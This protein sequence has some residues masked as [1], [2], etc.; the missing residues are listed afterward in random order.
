MNGFSFFSLVLISD[1]GLSTLFTYARVKS[2]CHARVIRDA[3]RGDESDSV[4]IRVVSHER[5]VSIVITAVLA[6][7]LHADNIKLEFAE[8]VSEGDN[9]IA[10]SAW[11]FTALPTGCQSIISAWSTRSARRLWSKRPAKVDNAR[12]LLNDN[13]RK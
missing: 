7:A 9:P 2:I 12:F 10:S 6:H 11:H 5:C 8:S 3:I 4:A 13:T 1:R